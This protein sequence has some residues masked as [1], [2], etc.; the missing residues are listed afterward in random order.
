MG[1]EFAGLLQSEIERLPSIYKLL[2]T[3]Y[4]HEELSYL[5]IGPIVALPEGTIKSY[6]FRA[7]KILKERLQAIYNK[8]I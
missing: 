4:H 6:L 8:G 1:A 3:L 7:R 2:I 5:E